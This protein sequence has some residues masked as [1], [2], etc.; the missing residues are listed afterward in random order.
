MNSSI[1]P[2][3]ACA[4]ADGSSPTAFTGGTISSAKSP[5]SF[6]QWELSGLGWTVHCWFLGIMTDSAFERRELQEVWWDWE[7]PSPVENVP[8]HGMRWALRSLPA[9]T[10]LG[11]SD[12]TLI[13]TSVSLSSATSSDLAL[14]QTTELHI[15]SQKAVLSLTDHFDR[16]WL[17]VK[18][19]YCF[20]WVGYC[21]RLVGSCFLTL[22]HAAEQ[23][24]LEVYL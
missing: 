18:I 21:T 15:L 20:R 14:R 12:Q 2:C 6:Y 23:A 3:P 13:A 19:W 16:K 9:Q 8:A 24:W 10:I 1:G 7:Q 5:K 4:G 22:T 17:I 11:F